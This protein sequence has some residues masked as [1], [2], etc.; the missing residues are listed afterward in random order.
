MSP[1]PEPKSL[2]HDQ[3]GTAI[4]EFAIVAP[5]MMILIMGLGDMLYQIYAQS[6]LT[7]AV[8]QAGRSS[9]IEGGAAN[10]SN[11]DTQVVVRMVGSVVASLT[12]SCA[13]SPATPVWCSQRENYDT[14]SAVAPEPFTDTNSNGVRNTGE[15]FTDVN[16]NGVWDANPGLAGQGGASDIVLYTMTIRYPRPFPVA[17]LIGFSSIATISAKTLLKN[18][19]YASQSVNPTPKV[20][21]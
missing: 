7:G 9:G 15:C 21:T 6:I 20:C 18:Q 14:F 12:P 8:Q 10:S 4:I 1:S 2:R 17:K 3:S 19:P 16:N 11:L 13:A 5:V